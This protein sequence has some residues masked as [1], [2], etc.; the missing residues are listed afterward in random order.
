MKVYWFA[1]RQLL[2]I[3]IAISAVLSFGSSI[4]FPFVFASFGYICTI[5]LHQF[6]YKNSWLMYFNIGYTKT[7]IP[8]VHYDL[9]IK[10]EK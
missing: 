1:Y 7:S 3:N 9:G 5:L 8:V 6:F 10:K 2:F 4:Y